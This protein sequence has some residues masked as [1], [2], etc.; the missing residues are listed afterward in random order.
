MNK[1]EV[2]IKGGY[3]VKVSGSEGNNVLWEVVENN[4]VEDEHYSLQN[5]TLSHNNHP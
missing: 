3:Y 2:L 4:V 5:L 1:K